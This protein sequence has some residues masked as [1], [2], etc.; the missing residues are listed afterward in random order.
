MRKDS[1]IDTID[2]PDWAED[3]FDRKYY[4]LAQ[5]ETHDCE[6]LLLHLSHNSQ[7]CLVLDQCCGTGKLAETLALQGHQMM[8]IDKNSY[9]IKKVC[10]RFQN[11]N[12]E[13]QFHCADARG[14]LPEVPVDFVIN[15][16]TSF[17]Y[18]E[19]D[20]ENKKF[21][22]Q[23]WKSLRPGGEFILEYP[24]KSHVLQNFQDVMISHGDGLAGF[25]QLRRH[26]RLEDGN[27]ILAQDW[28]YLDHDEVVG[29]KKSRLRLYDTG[30]LK[31]IFKE[32][33][34]ADCRI[35]ATDFVSNL[36]DSHKR[37]IIKGR[38]T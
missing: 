28:I 34:F 15:W 2:Q 19:S 20:T 35:L 1:E 5:N 10:E 3:F 13:G 32:S 29:R 36:D 14:F 11:L 38:R 22:R 27:S 31:M 7:K 17:G 26:S 33:G 12:L 24:N 6:A 25:T 4:S 8:G 18:F 30:E 23:A 21:V 16:Y 37:C 9:A